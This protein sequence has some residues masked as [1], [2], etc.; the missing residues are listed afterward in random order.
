MDSPVSS[1][2]QPP[3]PVVTPVRVLGEE[4][5]EDTNQP[6][7]AR[8]RVVKEF[9]SPSLTQILSPNVQGDN[10]NLYH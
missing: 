9:R 2:K 4:R 3:L 7:A 10:S 8:E 1:P 5:T 6:T